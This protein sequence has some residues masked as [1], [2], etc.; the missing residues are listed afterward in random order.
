MIIRPLSFTFDKY[1]INPRKGIVTFTYTVEFKY[2]FKKTFKD[3]LILKGIHRELWKNIPEEVLKPTLESLL[4]MLGINY[5]C[6]F[7]TN[8]IKI[9]NF[10]L[11]KEQAEF[12]EKLYLNG[13]GEFFYDMKM[14][15]HNLI[16]FP[17]EE[18]LVLEKS[19]NINLPKKSLLLN[20]AGKDSIL[21]AEILKSLNIPFDFFAFAPTPAH[22]K[23]A[24]LVD[25]K[26]IKVKR[27]F[28][29]WMEFYRSTFAI[30]NSYPSVST[31]TF[32][33]VL[34]SIL[35]GY[36]TIVFSNE[37]S[38][39]FGNFDYLGLEVNHQWCKSSEAEKMINDYIQKYITPDIKT[40]SLLRKYSELDIVRRFVKHERYLPYVTSC[41]NYFWLPPVVQFLMPKA[42]WCR[43]CPKCVF[44]FACFGA[45]LSKEKVL[46]IF[47]GNIYTDKTRLRLFRRILG[48]E[49]TKPLDCVGEPAE[50]ILAMHYVNMKKE[51][52]GEDA[53]ELFKKY[54]PN[55]YDFKK[56]EQEL[57]I[58]LDK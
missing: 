19:K 43:K 20:G 6:L 38:A 14:D 50:M 32:T 10:S 40:T 35:R 8:N 7:P 53:N 54:F 21:S 13:L 49:G 4:I 41:N 56:L 23:I 42:Y 16:K 5:W 36:D 2:G 11:T 30:S 9:K 48:V 25:T 24:K 27:K 33:A 18:N 31:F 58:D 55:N 39:D 44:L 46:K 29:F 47:G 52:E 1:K 51:Y 15:F 37:K 45:F 12:W 3:K 34:I 17:Y 22:K 57:F 28:D 26:T